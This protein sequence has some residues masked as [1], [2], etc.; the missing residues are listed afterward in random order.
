MDQLK[1]QDVALSDEEFTY[2]RKAPRSSQTIHGFEVF[3]DYDDA[4]ATQQSAAK[5][6]YDVYGNHLTCQCG[7][8]L[9]WLEMDMEAAVT[10]PC[11]I[12]TIQPTLLADTNGRIEEDNTDFRDLS[13]DERTKTTVT[14]T[15]H[16]TIPPPPAMNDSNT[17]CTDSRQVAHV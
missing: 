4:L 3:D 7:Q 16:T 10:P 1:T 14:N 2:S 8:C 13:D 6:T 12:C 9:S 11:T 5:R 17:E 15:E